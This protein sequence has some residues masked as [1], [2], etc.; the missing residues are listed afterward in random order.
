MWNKISK[1]LFGRKI[2]NTVVRES[3]YLNALSKRLATVET[4]TIELL[5]TIDS[6]NICRLT[7]ILNNWLKSVVNLSS[8]NV[9]A[10]ANNY[11]IR[12]TPIN[13]HDE[14]LDNKVA[15]LG[16]KLEKDGIFCGHAEIMQTPAGIDDEELLEACNLRGYKLI[17]HLRPKGDFK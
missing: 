9:Y 17:L 15:D 5:A 2:S 6:R 7:T 8:I 11:F 14:V 3:R 10:L 1:W 13:D 16:H 12:I 4:D